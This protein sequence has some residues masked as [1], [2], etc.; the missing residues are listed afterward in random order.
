MPRADPEMAPGK[1]HG[2]FRRSA[3]L[4]FPG[5]L[6][7]CGEH[8]GL[9]TS[10]QTFHEKTHCRDRAARGDF[11]IL[12]PAR[13]TIKKLA[14]NARALEG[15]DIQERGICGGTEAEWKPLE[16]SLG[17]PQARWSPRRPHSGHCAPKRM[18]LGGRVPSWNRRGRKRTLLHLCS[19]PRQDPTEGLPWQRRAGPLAR[20]GRRNGRASSSKT[21]RVMKKR[22]RR[23][24]WGQGRARQDETRHDTGEH[25]PA[26]RAGAVS[27]SGADDRKTPR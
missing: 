5:P 25:D 21:A 24:Q 4:M 18:H 14:G 20:T 10:G 8:S 26:R 1:N 23:A 15:F 16:V 22:A 7:P 11:F 6:P 19:R 2:P 12:W 13:A 27:R 9:T 17:A 3:Q